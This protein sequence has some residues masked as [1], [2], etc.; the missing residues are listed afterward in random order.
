DYFW[1]YSVNDTMA[2]TACDKYV[3]STG[4]RIVWHYRK[5]TP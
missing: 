5:M 3:T 4:D 2:Q 1:V